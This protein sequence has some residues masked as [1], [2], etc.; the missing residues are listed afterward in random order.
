MAWSN[1]SF[2]STLCSI[3]SS[4]I[5]RFSLSIAIRSAERPNGSTQLMFISV[6]WALC[7]ILKQHPPRFYLLT[8]LFIFFSFRFTI[9]I[10]LSLFYF[11]LFQPR[12]SRFSHYV[13]RNGSTWQSYLAV[14]FPETEPNENSTTAETFSYIAI[15]INCVETS[16]AVKNSEKFRHHG[17]IIRRIIRSFV[18]TLTRY[19]YVYTLRV[20]P[21]PARSLVLFNA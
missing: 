4:T 21:S 7:N 13:H 1:A 5:S 19:T 11:L 17:T 2:V 16:N 8:S 9:S 15:G 6:S 14:L 10:S 12:S 20:W 3:S 18:G